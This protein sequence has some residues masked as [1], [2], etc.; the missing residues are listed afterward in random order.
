MP[1][2]MLS[3]R[4]MEVTEEI[5]KRIE[6]I[7]ELVTN[8]SDLDRATLRLLDFSKQFCRSTE[9]A[10]EVLL[11]RQE[12]SSIKRH[13]RYAAGNEEERKLQIGLSR[14]IFKLLDDIDGDH[15]S[16]LRPPSSASAPQGST[17]AANLVPAA[18]TNRPPSQFE[19]VKS[20]F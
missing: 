10:R 11:T 15:A 13:I 14:R 4:S 18:Q 1:D 5:K 2:E 8:S 7:Q 17:R 12:F 3:E 16:S 9:L 20:K 6:E 19:N